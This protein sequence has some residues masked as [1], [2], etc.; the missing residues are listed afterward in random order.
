MYIFEL[1][2]SIYKKSKDGGFQFFKKQTPKLD[3][4]EEQK[5]EHIFVPIDST[6]KIL[7][8]S[9]CGFMVKVDPKKLEKQNIF[10]K[11]TPDEQ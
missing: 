5:C 1:I 3:V 6:K 2:A 4:Q 7:A 10:E 8:C 11:N 9:K